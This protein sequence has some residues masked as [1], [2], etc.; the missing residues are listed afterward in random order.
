T[1]QTGQPGEKGD[2]GDKG[3][4]GTPGSGNA[5]TNYGDGLHDIGE[6]LTQTVS[7]VTLPPGKYTLSATVAVVKANAD[8]HT[9]VQC[10]FV[11][12]GTLNGNVS[13]ASLEGTFQ[14]RMPLIGD[15]TTTAAT[16][17]VFL[18]CTALDADASAAGNMIALQVGT[19]TPSE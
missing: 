18:R 13:L 12:A 3:D 16:T 4:P 11:S 17:A 5:F 1:G 10:Y 14:V 9:H 15:V 19:I 8:D 7:S 6:G 2:K